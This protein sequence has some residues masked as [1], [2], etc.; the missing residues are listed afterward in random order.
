MSDVYVAMS[1]AATKCDFVETALDRF[2][3]KIKTVKSVFV[4]PNLVSGEPYPTTTDPLVLDAVLSYLSDYDVAVGDGPALDST[5][6]G[7]AGNVIR[8][9]PLMCVCDKHD[10]EFMNLNDQG[11]IRVKT[12]SNVLSMSAVPS[13]Y[14]LKISL[15]VLKSHSVCGLTGAIKNHFG[16]LKISDRMAMHAKKIDIHKGIAE[17]SLRDKFDIFIVDAVETLLHAQEVR[18][19]GEHA[20]LGYMLAGEDPVSIDCA[21]FEF[22]HTVDPNLKNKDVEDIVHIKYAALFGVGSMDYTLME[23]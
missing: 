9:H 13:S 7:K 10:I 11:Y 19:E 20:Y 21:G 5:W 4:K 8:D 16:L 6:D 3:N 14:D 1:S 17:I 18:H 2:N 15:P 23:V 22:L 12:D